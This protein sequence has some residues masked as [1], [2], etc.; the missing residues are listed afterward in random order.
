MLDLHYWTTPAEAAPIL[1]ALDGRTRAVL[2]PLVQTFEPH[3]GVWLCQ[4]L[5]QV[6]ADSARGQLQALGQWLNDHP[7]DVV[8]LIL[9]DDVS[10]A[11]VQATVT[12]A[13]LD[14]RLATP[15]S[16]GHPWPTLEE[17]VHSG[18]TLAVFTQT[19]KFTTGPIRNFY[20]YAAE[21]PF[22]ADSISALSCQPGRGAA[23]APLFLVNN[24]VTTT[25]PSRA[26]ALAVNGRQFLLG[27]V[28][29]CE[30]QRRL[31]ATFVAV[32]FTQVGQPLQV[33][34]ELNGVPPTRADP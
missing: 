15:P 28:Q 6:G 19:A 27:R 16:P 31:R 5:C 7:D 13:G 34:D 20:Q 25:I 12:A 30:I 10:A 33:I 14:R 2:A 8:T 18:R 1:A 26:D 3:P 24:W 32:D 9:Q 21:T 17:M 29:R 11:D 4:E 23:R 22:E